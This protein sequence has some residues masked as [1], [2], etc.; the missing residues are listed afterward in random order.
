MTIS[1]NNP[2]ALIGSLPGILGFTPE[3]SLAVVALKENGEIHCVLRVDSADVLADADYMA[4][5]ADTAGSMAHAAIAVW[6]TDSANLLCAACNAQFD[7][8]TERLRR[9]LAVELK[10]TYVTDNSTWH[11]ASGESGEVDQFT[12][13]TCA[14]ILEGRVVHRSRADITA[15][16]TATKT[17][18][19]AEVEDSDSALAVFARGLLDGKVRDQLYAVAASGD[20]AQAEQSLIEAA[21]VLPGEY[22]AHA[23]ATVAF[24]AYCRGDGVLAGE[25]V[26]Q[27]LAAGGTQMATMLD[28]AL[29]NGMEPKMIRK[30]A[31]AGVSK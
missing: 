30:L 10:A 23:L 31:T 3:A 5:L 26:E 24:F 25:A 16:L 9:L 22:R 12:S 11:S 13:V 14:S 8:A 15:L 19:A 20:A 29:R 1:I 17:V 4:R 21:R 2:G 6:V 18:P 27:S 28:A 7:A